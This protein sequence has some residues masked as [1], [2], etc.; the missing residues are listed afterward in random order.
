MRPEEDDEGEAMR[1]KGMETGMEGLANSWIVS[2]GLVGFGTSNG[3]GGLLGA[4]VSGVF[5]SRASSASS[6][7]SSIN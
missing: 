5:S 7:E 4:G 3:G 2:G 6:R 1:D